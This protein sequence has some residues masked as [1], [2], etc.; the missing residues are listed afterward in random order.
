MVSGQRLADGDVLTIAEKQGLD[1]A[2]LQEDMTSPSVEAQLSRTLQIARSLQIDGTPAFVFE[3][4][5]LGGLRS[6]EELASI[7]TALR[8]EKAN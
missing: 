2:R 5:V 3:G 1:T 7:A 4:Q 8:A 6:K